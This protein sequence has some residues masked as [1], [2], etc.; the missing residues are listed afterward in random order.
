MKFPALFAL[1]ALAA[2]PFA[3][4]AEQPS[5]DTLT[6]G[7]GVAAAP[8][9]SGADKT[10]ALPLVYVDYQRADGFFASSFRGLGYQGAVDKINFSAALA[11]D[12]GRKEK[13]ENFFVGSDRLK[14]MGDISPYAVAKLGIGYD[15]GP[16]SLNAGAN[17]AVSK[18]DNGN[19]YNF[20][21]AM[22][23]NVS[24]DDTLTLSL[25]T[26]YSDRKHVQTYYGVTAA[27]SQRSGYAAF[28]P[29]A[30]FEQ[31]A[32]SV[33]W[34]HKIDAHWSVRT[35]LGASH[36]MGD[37]AKSPLTQKKTTPM[38]AATVNYTF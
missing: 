13:R 22:P 28:T 30:G 21:V 24:T 10:R 5:K 7:A 36:L 2:T 19:T 34:M 14:G 8:E 18:R 15:L 4:A 23:L 37:A 27:Q 38:A 11:A 20:G 33:N 3:E 12:P 31:S 25:E 6:I 35:V 1:I 32:L 16:V 26:S 17:L 9:Y 29:K